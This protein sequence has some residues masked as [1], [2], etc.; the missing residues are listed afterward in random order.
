MEYV[1]FKFYNV[2][3]LFEMGGIK[4]LLEIEIFLGYIV[5]MVDCVGL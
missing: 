5:I 1:V 2:E 4:G 3:I